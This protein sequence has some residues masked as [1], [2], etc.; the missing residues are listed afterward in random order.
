M[1]L[2][3]T[4]PSQPT[5]SSDASLASL[6]ALTV[7]V[8]ERGRE[9]FAM[10]R[11]YEAHVAWLQ[12]WRVAEGPSRQLLQGLIQ[13]AGAYLKMSRGR[14]P[15]GMTVLLDLAL[16]RLDPLPGDYLGLDLEGF[17]RGLRRSKNE[18]VAWRA[19]GPVPSGPAHLGPAR[20]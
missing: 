20:R 6:A 9:E 4:D 13:A 16:E 11:F 3:Q 5:G 12:A 8:L 17:R 14:Q 10:G 18:A 7:T 15:I 1:T 2:L 19:G